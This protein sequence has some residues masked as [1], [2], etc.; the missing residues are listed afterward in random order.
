VGIQW[1]SHGF[2]KRENGRWKNIVMW[3]K[4]CCLPCALAFAIQIDKEVMKVIGASTKAAGN[5]DK[6][7]LY[8]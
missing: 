1:Q 7:R 4:G 6:V 8:A 5:Y 2:L 3:D